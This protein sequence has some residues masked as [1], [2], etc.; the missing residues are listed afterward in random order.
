MI[1]ECEHFCGV[2]SAHPALTQI[3]KNEKICGPEIIKFV[4][5]SR[6]FLES[7]GLN[8]R[9]DFKNLIAGDEEETRY[10]RV[11]RWRIHVPR[12]DQPFHLGSSEQAGDTTFTGASFAD[13]PEPRLFV[14][15]L[16]V[17]H[18]CPSVRVE[19]N[20]TNVGIPEELGC[21]L[22]TS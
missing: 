13:D 12:R 19:S 22:V 2:P 9:G 18:M 3:V 17:F 1:D 7:S 8:L 20:V 16:P 5:G 21:I 14:S 10:C 15:R 4:S 11:S 6:L